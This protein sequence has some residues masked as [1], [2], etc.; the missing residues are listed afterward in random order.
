VNV[1]WVVL[2]SFELNMNDR[3]YYKVLDPQGR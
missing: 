1:P 3:L 2:D